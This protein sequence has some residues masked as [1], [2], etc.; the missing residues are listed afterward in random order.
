MNKAL[1]N[2]FYLLAFVGCI[3]IVVWCVWFLSVLINVWGH[4]H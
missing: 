1:E 2:I 4:I 3:G